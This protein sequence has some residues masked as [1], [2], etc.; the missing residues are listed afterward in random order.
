MEL[1][2]HVNIGVTCLAESKMRELKEKSRQ[3]FLKYFLDIQSVTDREDR[4]LIQGV[5]MSIPQNGIKGLEID[6][7]LENS[8]V[9][10][11]DSAVSYSRI[12]QAQ[13]LSNDIIELA[14]SPS[15]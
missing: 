13:P 12:L 10:V 14:L 9:R 2:F 4:F 15:L 6:F 7:Y 1:Q 8:L 11:Q 5:F 3:V